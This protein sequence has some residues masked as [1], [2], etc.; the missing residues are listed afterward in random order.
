MNAETNAGGNTKTNT[1]TNTGTNADRDRADTNS[2]Y[3]DRLSAMQATAEQSQKSSS[4]TLEIHDPAIRVTT[5]ITLFSTALPGS[6]RRR[7]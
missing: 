5:S 7:A 1:E 3:G 2:F 4:L 6:N